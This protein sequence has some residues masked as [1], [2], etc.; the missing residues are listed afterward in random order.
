MLYWDTLCTLEERRMAFHIK[1]PE[2]D[3]MARRVAALKQIG[4]TEACTR[5][6]PMNLSAS[7][8]SR[9]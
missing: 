7:R 3:A 4:L 6:S 2:T 5:H 1:N 8:A 9:H